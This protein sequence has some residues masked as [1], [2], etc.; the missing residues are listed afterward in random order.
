MVNRHEKNVEKYLLSN[1][2]S[3]KKAIGRMKEIGEK[4]L[5][6]WGGQVL[7]Q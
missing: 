2:V 1:N 3:M 5:F 6:V 7:N 4:V